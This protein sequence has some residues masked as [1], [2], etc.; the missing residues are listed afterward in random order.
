MGCIMLRRSF[1][2][3]PECGQVLGPIVG[4]GSTQSEYTI[5]INTIIRQFAS[6]EFIELVCETT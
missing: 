5:S 3:V 4:P 1:H 6:S 2:N